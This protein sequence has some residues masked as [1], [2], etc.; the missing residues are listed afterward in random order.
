MAGLVH[1]TM[2]GI[3]PTDLTA[4]LAERGILIRDTHHPLANRISTGFYN[5][6]E[7]IARLV[8]AIA[9]IRRS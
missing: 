3:T 8:D 7:E 5:T 2:D 6:E 1:F 4:R 9:E